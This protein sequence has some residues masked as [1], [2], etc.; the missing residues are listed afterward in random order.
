[1]AA[2]Q[3]SYTPEFA[4]GSRDMYVG[5]LEKELETS[6]RV[7]GNIPEGKK[8][9]KPHNDSRSAWQLAVHIATSDIW[10]LDCVVAGKFEMGEG[11]QPEPAHTIAELNAWYDKNFRAA[12]AKVRK[13]TAAQLLKP[14]D[15]FGFMTAPLFFYLSFALVHA[16]HHRGQL[17]AYLRPMGAKVPD[18]YG[19][20]F[21]EPFK[22]A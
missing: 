6:K 13:L 4:T 7:I 1:M 17:S 19:G 20:S 10:F 11:E 9:Y 16:V 21:D 12:V 15:F 2:P 8:S 22:A 14:T 5:L 18:I 3:P